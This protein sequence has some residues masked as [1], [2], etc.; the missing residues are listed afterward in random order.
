MT[1]MNQKRMRKSKYV[2]LLLAGAAALPLAACDQAADNAVTDATLY[3]DASSCAQDFNP[4]ACEAAE[5][6]AK[7]EHI[8]TAPKFASKEQCEAAGFSACEATPTTNADGTPNTAA[9][10]SGGS[11]MPILMG[12][13]MG[14]MM[15]GAMAPSRPV[16]ADRTGNLYAGGNNVGRMA[17]GSTSLPRTGMPTRTVAR[18][19]FGQTAGRVGGGG[20]A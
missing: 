4:E 11:F 19:G 9:N 5:A 15:G 7:A 2:S 13:M 16:Y 10:Q 17:P 6:G 3:A 8:A 20:G 1:S 14:R 18:G 12:Y